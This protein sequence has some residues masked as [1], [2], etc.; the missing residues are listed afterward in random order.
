MSGWRG[1]AP[2]IQS[3]F[4]DDTQGKHVKVEKHVGLEANNMVNIFQD[5]TSKGAPS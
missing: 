5:L 1:D 4:S 3:M 2:S